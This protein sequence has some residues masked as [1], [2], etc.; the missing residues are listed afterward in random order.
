MA[1][2]GQ[3]LFSQTLILYAFHSHQFLNVA[4]SCPHL[5]RFVHIVVHITNP[6]S[7]CV[8]QLFNPHF[9]L[10]KLGHVCPRLSAFVRVWPR[11]ARFTFHGKPYSIC[12]PQLF[13]FLKNTKQSGHVYTHLATFVHIFV[14]IH[15]S[16]TLYLY[17]FPC[18]HLIFHLLILATFAWPR[19]ARFGQVW[20]HSFEA[21]SLVLY[22]F[23]RFKPPFKT[24]N[25][26]TFLATFGHILGH[27]HFSKTLYLYSFPRHYPSFLATFSLGHV[28]PRLSAFGQVWPHSIFKNSLPI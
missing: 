22:S 2:F 23:P 25:L 12:V 26:A 7:I 1:T 8:P 24:L 4:I 9:Y 27:I 13:N 6:Y 11:L 19:L 17:S 5:A 20:P 18:H 14:H 15:F 10:K 28:W 3:V 16:K 21:G